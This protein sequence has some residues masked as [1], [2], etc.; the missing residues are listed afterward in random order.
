MT[1][2]I[3]IAAASFAL[4]SAVLASSASAAD[5]IDKVDITKSGIDVV[6]I[7]VT[8]GDSGYKALKPTSH[9]FSLH[10]YAKAK[11]G[12]RIVA[13]ALGSFNGVEFFESPGNLWQQSLT[14]REIGGGEAKT[15]SRDYS[16]AVPVVKLGWQGKNPVQICNAML[17]QKVAG[18]MKK[19]D[20]LAKNWDV[21]AHVFF[22]FQAVAA[23][24][25]K[26]KK[27]K[28]SLG[29]TESE[30]KSLSYPVSVTCLSSAKVK[31]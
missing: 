13:G 14:G 20:V 28:W 8:A 9:N 12:K 11:S 19:S 23:K 2:K 16:V 7:Q 25:G 22:Q 6:P 5:W 26:A 4:A 24:T 18:G 3:I 30:R 1:R 29:N 10:L 15:F 31:M 17:Q 27:D 21:Q